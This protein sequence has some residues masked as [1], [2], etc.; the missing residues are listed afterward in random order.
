[1]ADTIEPRFLT[2]IPNPSDVPV[3]CVV[4]HNNAPPSDDLGLNQFRAWMES[5]DAERHA[6]VLVRVGATLLCL[7][8]LRW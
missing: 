7:Y 4:V 6:R 1:M 3:G 2:E 5:F 8:K